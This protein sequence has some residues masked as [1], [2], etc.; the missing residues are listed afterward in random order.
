MSIPDELF[1]L[2]F[3]EMGR[4]ASSAGFFSLQRRRSVGA[5]IPSTTPAFTQLP[6]E[7]QKSLQEAW[8]TFHE[9]AHHKTYEDFFSK[10]EYCRGLT[11]ESIDG[12]T[13]LHLIADRS[14]LFLEFCESGNDPSYPLLSKLVEN[15]EANSRGYSKEAVAQVLEKALIPTSAH[16]RY[17]RILDENLHELLDA[18]RM[19]ERQ[20]QIPLQTDDFSISISPQE[21]LSL[22]ERDEVLSKL[23]YA[24]VRACEETAYVRFSNDVISNASRPWSTA[25]HTISCYLDEHPCDIPG[26]NALVFFALFTQNAEKLLSGRLKK[27]NFKKLPPRE[28]VKA[29]PNETHARISRRIDCNIEL[30]DQLLEIFAPENATEEYIADAKYAFLLFSRYNRYWHFD[31]SG[32]CRG[33]GSSSHYDLRFGRQRDYKDGVDH[34]GNLIRYHIKYCIPNQADQLLPV[35]I[36]PDGRDWRPLATLTSFL[37]Y[38]SCQHVPTQQQLTHRIEAFLGSEAG[39]D[40]FEKYVHNRH[41]DYELE[42]LLNKCCAENDFFIENESSVLYEPGTNAKA[43]QRAPRLILEYALRFRMIQEAERNLE[44]VADVL[45][46][47]LLP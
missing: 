12:Q 22:S 28:S 3:S 7:Q 21:P 27:F 25:V 39:K 24:Y 11:A 8:Y 20:L 13:F 17:Y 5:S 1:Q 43:I 26:Y 40:T 45:F 31:L 2:I 14:F 47:S 37:L 18:K 15:C 38:E 34:L 29:D 6:K 42:E 36:S 19:R 23:F 30:F 41:D 32:F 9:N 10:I 44:R 16:K 4:N 33:D 35:L 46:Q